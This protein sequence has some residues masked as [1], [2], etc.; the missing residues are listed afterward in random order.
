MTNKNEIDSTLKEWVKKCKDPNI[1]TLPPASK[2]TEEM[3]EALIYNNK[4]EIW[5]ELD[6]SNESLIKKLHIRKI[7]KFLNNTDN[8]TIIKYLKVNK[9]VYFV[10]P[11]R[12]KINQ[13][14]VRFILTDKKTFSYLADIEKIENIIPLKY[15]RDKKYIKMFLNAFSNYKKQYALSNPHLSTL[16]DKMKYD[17]NTCAFLFAKA[18]LNSGTKDNILSVCENEIITQKRAEKKFGMLAIKNMLKL[19]K[20]Y[21]VD[22]TYCDDV[23][24]YANLIPKVDIWIKDINNVANIILKY[25]DISHYFAIKIRSAAF[26]TNEKLIDA[27]KKAPEKF[28]IWLTIKGLKVHVDKDIL[29]LYADKYDAF[30]ELSQEYL[31]D[32]EF[33]AEVIRKYDF[34]LL[35][36][37]DVLEKYLKAHMPIDKN[38]VFALIDRCLPYYDF[39]KE[40]IIH[41]EEVIKKTEEKSFYDGKGKLYF[42]SPDMCGGM[43]TDSNGRIYNQ[44]SENN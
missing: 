15:M 36:N 11:K 35:G 43:I 38:L 34:M 24:P 4:I 40:E 44:S 20:K 27:V 39:T 6:N 22:M 13:D 21:E 25:P 29:L 32:T 18:F 16:L 19:M 41:D 8:K 9:N 12:K 14:I 23:K 37:E 33:M 42:P 26:L 30:N 1:K 2:L 5:N 7:R 3:L 10:L 31:D 28:E 17:D